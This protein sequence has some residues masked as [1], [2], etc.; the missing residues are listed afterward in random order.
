MKYNIR[1]IL[2]QLKV[3]YN[4]KGP[5]NFNFEAINSVF[6]AEENTLTWINSSLPK[7]EIILSNCKAN[8]VLCDEELLLKPHSYSN[9]TFIITKNPQLIFLKILKII[10]SK[11]QINK[12]FIHPTAIIDSKAVIGKRV[13]IGPYALVGESQ[14]GND[15]KVE[16]FA[17]IHD[18]VIIGSNVLISEYCNIGGQGFGHI[19]NENGENEN[20]PHVGNVIIENG[21]EIFPFSNVDRATLSSTVI[22][23]NTKIDHYC[24]IG[25]NT[26]TGENSIITAKVV[27]SGGVII[28]SSCWIGVG[29]L[30]R[31]KLII[32]NSVITGMGSVVTKDIPDNELWVGN[33]ACNFDDFKRR[34]K[35]QI[36]TK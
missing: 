23:K 17:K 19:I 27:I 35:K 3:K 14:I 10:F 1:K 31:E 18:N 36:L 12:S 4:V 24:H 33:P 25:H 26:I 11:P 28:G 2:V 15:T 20:M 8:I 30:I 22:K 5:H 32:G 6:D 16:A 9:K 13:S 21:V 34:L 7:S 29:T